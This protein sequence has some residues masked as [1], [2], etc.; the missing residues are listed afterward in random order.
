MPPYF[1][2]LALALANALCV[3]CSYSYSSLPDI[4]F[5]GKNVPGNFRSR[6]R[7]FRGTFAPGRGTGKMRVAKLR[8]GILRVEVRAKRASI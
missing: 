7:K 6:E 8:V 2:I 5:R 1:S 4:S 3:T